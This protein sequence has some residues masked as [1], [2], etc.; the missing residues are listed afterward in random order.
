M[1]ATSGV[2]FI[3]DVVDRTGLAYA[4][5]REGVRLGTFPSPT[6]LTAKSSWAVWSA[7]EVAQWIADRS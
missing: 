7:A 6:A 2:L 5:V 1:P 4:T 3:G